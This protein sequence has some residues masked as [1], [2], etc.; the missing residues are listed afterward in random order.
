MPIRPVAPHTG[1]RSYAFVPPSPMGAADEIVSAGLTQ[2]HPSNVRSHVQELRSWDEFIGIEREWNEL[3]SATDNQIFFRHE[4][5]RVWCSHFLG[6]DRLRVLALR[7]RG[8]ALLALLPLIER[9]SVL[10]GV[11]ITELAS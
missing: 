7:S 11:P 2:L 6:G 9:R 5:L 3:V 10:Y 1:S 4:F 8:G